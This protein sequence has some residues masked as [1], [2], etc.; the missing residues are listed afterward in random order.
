MVIS[1]LWG[2]MAENDFSRWLAKAL[3]EH[4]PVWSVADLAREMANQEIRKDIAPDYWEKQVKNAQTNI[5]N[6][7]RGR[8]GLGTGY[9]RRIAMALNA[10]LLEV[11]AAANGIELSEFRG[12]NVA[13]GKQSAAEQK[14]QSI[15]AKLST[16]DLEEAANLLERLYKDRTSPTGNRSPKPR[17]Q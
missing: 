11:L 8:A 15:I 17:S 14:I 6:A 2:E 1:I 7:I 16:E 5:S 9:V 4:D 12:E 3:A 10:N 13:H